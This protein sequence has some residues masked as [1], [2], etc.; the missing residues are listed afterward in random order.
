MKRKGIFMSDFYNNTNVTTNNIT[1]TC[2]DSITFGTTINSNSTSII[3]SWTPVNGLSNPAILNP[4]VNPTHTTTYILNAI[5]QSCT[6]SD[7][8]IVTVNTANFNLNFT[9][10]DTLF[11][12]PPFIVQFNNNTPDITNYNFTWNFGD[13]TI[14]NSNN[15]IVN[16]TYYSN[17]MYSVSLIATDIVNSCSDTI[18][19][20]S[21][22][23]CNGLGINQQSTNSFKFNVFPNPNKGEFNLLLTGTKAD[24]YNINLS[25]IIGENIYNE[26]V[27][28][29]DNNFQK[30][31]HL[32][33]IPKGL[34][35][36]T[37]SSEQGKII[38]KIV[39]Q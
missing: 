33:N 17:G 13:D 38:K 2:G 37:I 9:A 18:I 5:D 24:H 26:S 16:H 34:Y 30:N 22:I 20:T 31:I 35:F 21:Y 3:Y 10:N 6:V 12:S 29:I 4:L 25:S 23:S 1:K 7:T 15:A 36:V 28:S 27:Q 32:T 19:K 39:I 14:L 11:T 8:V